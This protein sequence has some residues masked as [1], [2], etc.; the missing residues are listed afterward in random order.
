M[1]TGPGIR[2][3]TPWELCLAGHT[4]CPWMRAQRVSLGPVV[5]PLALVLCLGSPELTCPASVAWRP[6]AVS[7]CGKNTRPARGFAFFKIFLFLSNVISTE[8]VEAA[9]GGIAFC[10]FSRLLDG[11]I[12]HPT[13]EMVKAKK[14]MLVHSCV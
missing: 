7:K 4:G 13:A 3:G 5:V 10:P 14:S 8:V 1:P 12:S 9:V 2:L 11:A 6:W